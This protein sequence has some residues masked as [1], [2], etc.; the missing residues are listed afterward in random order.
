MYK[1]FTDQA[2]RV[3][4]L[5]NQE[6]QRFQHEYIG[7]EHILL[8]LIKE[9]SCVAAKL[10][11]NLGVDLHGILLE[12]NQ[13]IRPGPHPVAQGRRPQTPR[14]KR[15]IEYTMEEARILNA[16][17]VGTEHI[18]LGLL[19][20]R[21]G[22][23]AQVLVNLGM[24]LERVRA[25]IRSSAEPHVEPTPREFHVVIT[26]FLTDD[27]R[28]EREVLGEIAEVWAFGAHDEAELVGRI[29]EADAIILYHQ[30]ALTR[31][32]L[33]RL[34]RCKLIVRGGVGVDNVDLPF[35]RER[36]IPV[37]NVPDYGSEEVA[38]TAI[39][40]M[41]SLVRGT[42]RLNSRLRA[43]GG[44]WSH[45]LVVPLVRLRGRPFGVIGLGRIGTAAALRAKA[46]GMDVVFYDPYKPDG[47]DKALGIRRVE[48]LPELLAEALVV[49]VHCPLT[50]ETRHM[51]DAAAI[52]QMPRGSYL[53]N[54]ARGAIV[55]TRAIP[56]ALASGH[57]AGAG[58]DV[59]E[60]EPPPD[61]HPLVVAWRDP[62]H[63][64]HHRLIITS[65]AAFY[66]E[67][68]LLDIRVKTAQ[69]CRRALLGQPLRNVVN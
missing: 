19:R 52:A 8:G 54:T 44:P 25:E 40:M 1:R 5:A 56:E 38:D 30:M 13:L 21:E 51:V 65:H 22:V 34:P 7:T 6:A 59:L 61:D 69:A 23:G 64:A 3:M 4:Q 14:A 36:G 16:E 12:V 39:A 11:G 9:D 48:M 49:S 68:G 67:Q 66:S 32:T 10:L 43:G 24:T 18:L 35:A 28:P 57:L 27:L 26:D 55:D 17:Y 46:M 47:S 2:R 60:T 29:E 33:E 31:S 53:V 42:H 37:A 20:E 63:P 15:V 58:L 50:D 62:D 41:M 45:E